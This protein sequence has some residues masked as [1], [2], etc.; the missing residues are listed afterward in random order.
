[1]ATIMS[2]GDT[3]NV[4]GDEVQTKFIDTIGKLLVTFV[5]NLRSGQYT[6]KRM[7]RCWPTYSD[8]YF[9]IGF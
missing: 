7:R 4:N 3:A 1:M 2:N 5:K 8:D 6:N 9:F